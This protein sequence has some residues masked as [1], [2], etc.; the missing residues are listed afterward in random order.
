MVSESFSSSVAELLSLS[1]CVV[2]TMSRDSI[3]E[4]PVDALESTLSFKS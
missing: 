3:P 4:V 2:E 1:I